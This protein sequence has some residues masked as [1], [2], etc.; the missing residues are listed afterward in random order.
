MVIPLAILMEI[1]YILQ[2]LVGCLFAESPANPTIIAV[3]TGGW[4]IS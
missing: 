2:G 4:R 3:L 1:G